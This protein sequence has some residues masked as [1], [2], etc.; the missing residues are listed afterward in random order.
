METVVRPPFLHCDLSSNL[1]CAPSQIRTTIDL[2]RSTQYRY[3]Q[4]ESMQEHQSA[5]GLRCRQC[6]N[7]VRSR[8]ITVPMNF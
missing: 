5:T 6:W 2:L 4:L 1:F 3:H 7:H 8:S